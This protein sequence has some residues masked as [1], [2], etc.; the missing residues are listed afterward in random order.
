MCV[1]RDDGWVWDCG[2]RGWGYVIESDFGKAGYMT[3]DEGGSLK[4]KTM[5]YVSGWRGASIYRR[6]TDLKERRGGSASGDGGRGR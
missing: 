4:A 6:G 2:G 5:V 1:C 3:N